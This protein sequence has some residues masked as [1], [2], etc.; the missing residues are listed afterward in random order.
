MMEIKEISR[1]ALK[2]IYD[3]H[4]VQDFPADELK[5]WVAIEALYDHGVYR[6]YGL[7]EDEELL[8]YACL[9]R[10]KDEA[11][12]LL[13]YYAVCAAYRSHG[14]GSQFITML[15]ESLKEVQGIFVEIELIGSAKDETER[16]VRNRR[17]KFYLRNG[18]TATQMRTRLFGVDYEMLFMPCAGPQLDDAALL[19][20]L[21]KVYQTMLPAKVFDQFVQLSLAE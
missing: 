18:L 13:D 14:Y 4:M 9:T 12:L 16:Q 11:W 8:A 21:R 7:Y 6:S 1:E 15:W 17:R 5:P 19:E 10:Q 2:P 3:K 20:E